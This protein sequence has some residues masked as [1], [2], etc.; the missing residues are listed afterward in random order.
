MT[1]RLTI[2]ARG[3]MKLLEDTIVLLGGVR[4]WWGFEYLEYLSGEEEKVI[5]RATDRFLVV[6][7]K[8]RIAW[9]S[10]TQLREL[11]SAG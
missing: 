7:V 3:E 2:G 6:W 8:T 1:L 4:S 5:V 9:C 10:W 11:H